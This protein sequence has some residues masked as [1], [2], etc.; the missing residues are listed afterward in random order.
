MT[1]WNL[2]LKYFLARI[3]AQ[4]FSKWERRICWI[5][6]TND[7]Q[8]YKNSFRCLKWNEIMRANAEEWMKWSTVRIQIAMIAKKISMASV[9]KN[10][11]RNDRWTQI[12]IHSTYFMKNGILFCVTLNR[13]G[14][15][16]VLAIA[17]YFPSCETRLDCIRLWRE[18]F[19]NIRKRWSQGTKKMNCLSRQSHSLAIIHWV[20]ATPV[21]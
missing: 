14:D 18:E 2:D 10:H 19:C 4:E 6:N 21:R 1:N 15:I 20:L 7:D 5:V 16:D 3:N 17:L 11:H 12:S 9:M 13:P 8:C